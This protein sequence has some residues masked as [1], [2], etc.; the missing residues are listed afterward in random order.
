MCAPQTSPTKP[1]MA[2]M[3][4]AIAHR[5]GGKRR[6]KIPKKTAL[7]KKQH[8]SRFTLQL[9][10]SQRWGNA[11]LNA[12]PTTPPDSDSDSVQGVEHGIMGRRFPDGGLLLLRYRK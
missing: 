8:K 9:S 11:A 10:T 5:P 3:V 6:K 4:F 1:S 7:I 2:G 12:D